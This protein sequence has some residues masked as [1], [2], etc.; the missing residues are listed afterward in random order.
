WEYGDRQPLTPHER[1]VVGRVVRREL[2]IPSAPAVPRKERDEPRKDRA[3]PKKDTPAPGR[4]PILRVDADE[5]TVLAKVRWEIRAARADMHLTDA[6]MAALEGVLRRYLGE[7]SA[8][9]AKRPAFHEELVIAGVLRDHTK[10][11]ENLGLKLA[12][13]SDRVDLFLSPT[14]TER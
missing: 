8:P 5:R 2:D 11:E 14:M 1:D 13:Q 7:P 6:D 10:E 3:V 9:E 12:A 4:E